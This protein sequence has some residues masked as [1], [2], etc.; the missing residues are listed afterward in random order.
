MAASISPWQK[1]L[2]KLN[3]VGHIGKLDGPKTWLEPVQPFVAKQAFRVKVP[4]NGTN[5]AAIY[6]AASDLGDGNDH[7]YVV[8]QEPKFVAP[9][10]P[11]LLLR[12]VRQAS[13][14]LSLLRADLFARTDKYL[15]AVDEAANHNGKVDAAALAAKHSLDTGRLRAWL[16]ILGLGNA[17]PVKVN[18]H[19]TNK[20]TSSGAYPFIQGWGRSR[21]AHRRCQFLRQARSHPR[22]HEAAR[23]GHSAGCKSEHH[24]RLAES[25]HR[26]RARHSDD[27]PRPSQL[28][29]PCE[30]VSRAQA[31][32]DQNT[33]GRGSRQRAHA[34]KIDP[35]DITI[36][37]D[38]FRARGRSAGESHLRPTAVDLTITSGEQTWDIAKDCADNVLAGNPHADRLGNKSAW[39]FIT[40]PAGGE[41]RFT[42]ARGSLL[43]RWKA[44]PTKLS[45]RNWPPRCNNC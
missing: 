41:Q 32:R 3:S 18:G 19:L 2:W 43:E 36:R 12:D 5:E 33:L 23:R 25:D 1:A 16:G 35:M 27:F 34:P 13:R 6:L 7:D 17:E 21:W 24:R 11:D 30:L 31:L 40:E 39:H 45:E 26:H 42:I 28:R 15:A 8:W 38:D 10:R 4:A 22:Q 29:L 14:E 9:G 37:A 44:Q 20:I